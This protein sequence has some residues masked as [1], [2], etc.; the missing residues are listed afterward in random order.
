MVHSVCC[1]W[2]ICTRKRFPN[3]LLG[4]SPHNGHRLLKSSVQIHTRIHITHKS[5]YESYNIYYTVRNWFFYL[6]VYIIQK[7]LTLYKFL[8]RYQTREAV[9]RL[10]ASVIHTFSYRDVRERGTIVE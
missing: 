6:P 4:V 2:S 3:L 8:N 10:N 5:L 7:L 9:V 1:D